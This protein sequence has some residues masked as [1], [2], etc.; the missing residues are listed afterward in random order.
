[1]EHPHDPYHVRPFP[2]QPQRGG[3]ELVLALTDLETLL[4]ESVPDLEKL[5]LI[6]GRIHTTCNTFN[7]DRLIDMIRQMSNDLDLYKKAPSKEI[8]QKIIHQLLKVRVEL[9]HL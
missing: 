7:D 1:M 2:Q 5:R 8:L 9:K 6:Q 3:K 4:S